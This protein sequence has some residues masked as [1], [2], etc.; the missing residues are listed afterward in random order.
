VD[1]AA[2]HAE[3][4]VYQHGFAGDGRVIIRDYSSPEGISA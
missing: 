2:L 1:V 3:R 4:P